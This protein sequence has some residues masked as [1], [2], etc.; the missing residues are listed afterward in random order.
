VE[1][2]AGDSGVEV[3]LG[4]VFPAKLALKAEDL[5]TR[6]PVTASITTTVI[7]GKR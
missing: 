5:E 4:V 3:A 2:R 6:N 1:I 7:R